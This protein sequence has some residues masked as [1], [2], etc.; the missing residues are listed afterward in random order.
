MSED[1]E[2]PLDDRSTFAPKNKPEKGQAEDKAERLDRPCYRELE[3]WPSPKH[4]LTSE[5][6]LW[7][8]QLARP[9]PVELTPLALLRV[10]PMPEVERLSGLSS[11]TIKKHYR[12]LL[13]RVS[14]RRIG[15]RVRDALAIAQAA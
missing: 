4:P 3:P 2:P 1:R 12:H 13:V 8:P 6:E 7:A 11:D 15:M 10:A 9:P 14:P 5:Q